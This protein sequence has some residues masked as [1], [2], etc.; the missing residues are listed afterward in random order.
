LE[1]QVNDLIRRFEE[2]KMPYE[3]LIIPDDSHHWM[4]YSNLVKVNKATVEFL[5]KHLNP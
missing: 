3:Y 2:R 5:K 1:R 4:K